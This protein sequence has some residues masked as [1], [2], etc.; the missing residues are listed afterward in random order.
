MDV[1]RLNFSHGTHEDHARV[2]RLVQQ[3]ANEQGRRVA[4]L[5]D[6]SGPKI[7][8]GSL[9]DGRPRVLPIR[10]MLGHYI[11]HR[12]TVV[13]RRTKYQL[14]KALDRAHILEGL[15]KAVENSPPQ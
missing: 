4:I 10:D 7:R 6:L 2:A 11:Q 13:I 12:K 8:T 3:A 15:K 1:A 14:K 5:Q 9:V